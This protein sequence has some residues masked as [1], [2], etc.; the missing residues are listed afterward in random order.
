MLEL[1]VNAD[2]YAALPADMQ[3]IVTYAARAANQDMLDE[4]TARNNA[5]LRDLVENHGVQ[6]RRL[7]DDVLAA[8]YQGNEKVINQLI[9]DDAMAAKV[10]ESYKSFYDGARAYHHISEQA[11][12]NARDV[13]IDG[14]AQ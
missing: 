7:P 10:Y 5:A 2:S 1:I 12:I 8:L 4:F 6:L 9:A 11:Y 14:A 13:V 3:A